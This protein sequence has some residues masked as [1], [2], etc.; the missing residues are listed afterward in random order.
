M[1]GGA[2]HYKMNL[3][4]DE[5]QGPLLMVNQTG[6]TQKMID[7]LLDIFYEKSADWERPMM[8]DRTTKM[9]KG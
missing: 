2:T 8:T 9:T 4:F 1:F 6:K 5:A 3:R 7:P